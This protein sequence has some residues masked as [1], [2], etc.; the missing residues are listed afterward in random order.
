MHSEL[1]GVRQIARRDKKVK[2][3]ALFH[4]IT[5]ERLRL[6]FMTTNRKAATGVDAVTWEQYEVNLK[7]NLLD[8]HQRL[9]RGA[10]RARP[11][12]MSTGR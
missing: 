10:Y 8:L 11:Y 6:A 9:R 5:I 7:A 4:H 1:E 12:V 3:T 2:F